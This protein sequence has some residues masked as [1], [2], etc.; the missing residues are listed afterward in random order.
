MTRRVLLELLFPAVTTGRLSV[1]LLTL[2]LFVGVAFSFHGLAKVMDLAAFAAE[3]QIPYAL[4]AVAAYTQVAGA[5]LLIA[6]FVTPVAASALAAT[7]AVAMAELIARGERF[8]DPGG[9]SWEAP[10]FYFVANLVLAL[11]GPGR[12]S[13]DGLISAAGPERQTVYWRST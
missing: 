2:R 1:A 7:M 13:V 12:W 8:V 10:A 4:A 9:H 6:G 5:L 3:F 11:A